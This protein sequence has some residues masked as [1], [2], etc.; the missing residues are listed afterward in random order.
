MDYWSFT[1]PKCR[2]Y[3][4]LKDWLQS[5]KEAL[6][7]LQKLLPRI[8]EAGFFYTGP[9]DRV[10]CFQCGFGLL[11][12]SGKDEPWIDHPYC[13]PHCEFLLCNKSK[14]WVRQAFNAYARMQD[15]EEKVYKKDLPV[16]KSGTLKCHICLERNLLIA[17]FTMWTLMCLCHVCPRTETLSLV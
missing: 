17:F 2:R 11:D 1:N 12:W 15:G 14:K 7:N 9:E 5:Y 6:E 3:V 8:A 13:S 10:R 4:R 16:D